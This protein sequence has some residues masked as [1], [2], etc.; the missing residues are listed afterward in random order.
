MIKYVKLS[1]ALLAIGVVFA[2]FPFRSF[3]QFNRP[4]I[5]KTLVTP[6]AEVSRAELRRRARAAAKTI[7]VPIPPG[8][9]EAPT[10]LELRTNGLV[11]K[12][13]FDEAAAEF[14]AVD[15]VEE[16]L[17][18]L[19][20]GNSCADCHRNPFGGH[21]TT[22]EIN[23]G[24]NEK[25]GK[26]IEFISAPGGTIIALLSTNAEFQERV[27][28]LENITSRRTTLS[29]LGL[30]FLES[31][32]LQTRLDIAERQY[33][34]TNG[35]IRGSIL[36]VDDPEAPMKKSPGAFG[37][38]GAVQRLDLFAAGAYL[39]EMGITNPRFPEEQTSLG[40]SVAEIDPAKDPEDDGEDV[41]LFAIFMRASLAPS[42][43]PLA[44]T[45]AAK[46]GER[47]F[48]SIGCARCHVQTLVT[49]AAGTRIGSFVVPEGLALK[50]FHPFTDLLLHDIGTGD[51]LP[52]QDAP[53]ATRNLF[54][55][56]P[57][58]LL[59]MKPSGFLHDARAL[60]LEQAVLAHSGEA[61]V[62]GNAFR[63]LKGIDKRDLMLFLE[64]L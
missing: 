20:N 49:A 60:S 5:P 48:E 11:P 43:S 63:K 18:P 47:V 14:G 44:T 52:A 64:T 61:K 55:T 9:T 62:E 19:R 45:Q 4:G 54:R 3:A 25:R 57:L 41:E 28:T 37:H 27:P 38:K 2:T 23:A 15:S 42:R 12:E 56:P 50:I 58:W 59:R 29:V 53:L 30:G 51:G 33:A 40:R 31:V 39:V 1:V 17:G 10:G 13:K 22:I 32:S 21:G 7:A 16:G 6:G 46:N 34:D 8:A 36:M 26:K 35:R 24:H